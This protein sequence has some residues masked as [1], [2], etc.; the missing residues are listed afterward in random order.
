MLIK[1]LDACTL[2]GFESYWV[3]FAATTDRGFLVRVT[4]TGTGRIRDYR[5]PLGTAAQPVTDTSA[6]G[7]VGEGE[8]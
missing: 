1:V 2:S 3:F 6:F 5:S 8:G 7:C 4:D